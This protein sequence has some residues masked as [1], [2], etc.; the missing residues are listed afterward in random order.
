MLS[1]IKET[2]QKR[3]EPK[4]RWFSSSSM[5]LFIWLNDD[6]EIVSYQLTYNKPND[7]KAL[8]WSKEH[9]F[10][11]LGV[12]D[13]AR[14]GKYPASPLLVEDGVFDPSKLVT[15]LI[16]NSAELEPSIKNFIVS[17]I[18]EHFK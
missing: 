11:H 9:G 14:P 17:G 5:D 13:G 2:S 10:S 15:M 1:E 16:E 7:E 12:D 18:E 6:E 8:T 3:G 4:K